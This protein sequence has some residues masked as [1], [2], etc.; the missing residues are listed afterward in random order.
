MYWLQFS[1]VET[2]NMA[3]STWQEPRFWRTTKEV[4]DWLLSLYFILILVSCFYIELSIRSYFPSTPHIYMHWR[5]ILLCAS[6]GFHCVCVVDMALYMWYCYFVQPHLSV[7]IGVIVL[8]NYIR[9]S[10]M[11]LYTHH[12]RKI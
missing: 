5:A 2:S 8:K 12:N 1:L 7:W 10:E 3:I 6:D 11:L 9:F 4:I